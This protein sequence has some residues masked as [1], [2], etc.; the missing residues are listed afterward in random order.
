MIANC[1]NTLN[2]STVIALNRISQDPA[3]DERFDAD[4]RPNPPD[5]HCQIYSQN[6]GPFFKREV[7][8]VG[9]GNAK[10]CPRSLRGPFAFFANFALEN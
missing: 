6:P 4:Q 7:R 10:Y 8:E 5:W 3:W 2:P 9:E 1:A